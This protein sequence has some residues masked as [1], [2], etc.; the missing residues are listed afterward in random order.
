MGNLITVVAGEKFEIG[1]DVL[2]VVEV[3]SEHTDMLLVL[4]TLQAQKEEESAQAQVLCRAH[5][6]GSERK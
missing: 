2:Q 6:L 1:A 5:S 4:A 3:T